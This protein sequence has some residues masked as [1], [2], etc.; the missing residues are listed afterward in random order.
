MRSG[1]LNVSLTPSSRFP[2]PEAS[3]SI[4]GGLV[5]LRLSF[6][7]QPN[8]GKLQNSRILVL[9]KSRQQ[10]FSFPSPTRPLD[11]A[12]QQNKH[13]RPG[14][15]SVAYFAFP[16]MQLAI[17]WREDGYQRYHKSWPS[18]VLRSN[19]LLGLRQRDHTYERKGHL[20]LRLRPWGCRYYSDG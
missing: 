15:L 19:R 16:L 7:Y 9:D 3:T 6:C 4:N 12:A 18:I 14:I 8:W 17:S 5:S 20:F 1:Y 13:N 10:N 2:D 11:S